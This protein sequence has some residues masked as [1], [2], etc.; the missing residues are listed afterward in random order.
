MPPDNA[1]DF[2]H[3]WVLPYR[4]DRIREWLG[5][6]GQ[7]TLED[8]LE[9]QNDEFSSVMAS[10]LPKMLEQ[11]SDPELRASE[12]FALLQGWNHQAAADLAAPL[13]AGYWVRA[14]TRELLQP[15]IG[16]QLLAS[17]W[18]QR[19]Y[20]GFLR[21]ILDGQADLR[22]WCGQEQGCDLKL[23]QSLRRALDEL[24]AAHGSAPSGWKWGEAHAALAEHVPFHKTPL[25]TLF[26]LKNNKG[27]DNFSVNVG[28][29]D[30]SD[31]ANPFNTR[32]AATLRMVIDLADFDNS[33]YAL[34][35]RNSGLPFDGATDLN[36]LWARG[37]YIRIA[38]DTPD[39]TDRQLVLRPSAS[40]SGE[41]RP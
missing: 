6:P 3:D 17:G 9:L 23:N 20:D 12:A 28:R 40:S 27:G 25:R 41:P 35:T 8:S 11:V 21:L 7:R 5:G 36:E 1:F 24:R 33:R 34:S 31:P 4:Y 32:I 16:T 29:F 26:D 30:Y 13:I 19:N 37:A 18:N 15:R 39:A 2:G 22:F 38:D 14:F 10:L